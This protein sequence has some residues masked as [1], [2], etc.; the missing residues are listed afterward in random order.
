MLKHLEQ[1]KTKALEKQPK[2][3]V[4]V[5]PHDDNVMEAII[6]AHNMGIIIPIL[7]GN[8]LMMGEFIQTY[9][10]ITVIQET[11][12][13]KASFIAMQMVRDHQADLVM[14]G[15][16]DSHVL[17]K[18]VVHKQ[19]GIKQQPLL[20]HV[21]LLEYPGYDRVIFVTDGAMN[22]APSVEHKINIIENAVYLARMLDD[23]QPI[24]GLVSAVEKM[25]EKMQST[26]DAKIILDY[27]NHKTDVP[28]VIDGPYAIDNLV[29][30]NAVNL[31]GLGGPVAGKANIFVFPN[32]ESGNVF[33]KTSVFLAHAA[34]AGIVLGAQVP[35]IVT[36]R[37]DSMMTK[38][39]S[40]CLG[41]I[42]A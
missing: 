5:F 26:V 13:I 21:G 29:S 42:L 15:L 38:L 19:L 12:P 30:I 33:Y 25:N 17:L 18:A 6:T 31:K 7:I 16:I 41:V 8:P 36:S 14:K 20:S 32:I 28:F 22:I 11:D 39:Y 1:L 40:I 10:G 2:R 37:A 35:I 9:N 23:D 34:S 4:V 24:V 27:Y 3:I